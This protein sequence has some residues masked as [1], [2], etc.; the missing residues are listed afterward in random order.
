MDVFIDSAQ[1]QCYQN[2][3]HNNF[4]HDFFNHFHL[5]VFSKIAAF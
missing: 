5:L 4:F 3:G 2:I 1:L